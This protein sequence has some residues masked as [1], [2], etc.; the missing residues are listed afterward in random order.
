MGDFS[1]FSFSTGQWDPRKLVFV[2]LDV[3]AAGD[4]TIVAA[5]VANKIRVVAVVLVV[6]AA[7]TVQWKSGAVTLSGPMAFGANGGYS[8]PSPTIGML[9]TAVNTALILNLLAAT[10]VSGHLTYVLV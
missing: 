8:H 3:S 6:T 9:E 5:Q 7:N 4:N 2:S 1:A 10:Q